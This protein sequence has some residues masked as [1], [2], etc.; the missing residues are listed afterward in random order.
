MPPWAM[1]LIGSAGLLA[2]WVSGPP[3]RPGSDCRG[4]HT[5]ASHNASWEQG[6]HRKAATC[7]DCHLPPGPSLRRAQA[8]AADGLR[9]AAIE[10][11]HPDPSAIRLHG[12]G[13]EVVQANCLRCHPRRPPRPEDVSPRPKP[14][15]G[16]AAHAEAARACA[17]C[18]R[19][20]GHGR[21]AKG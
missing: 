6:G 12:A 5:M 10:T 3:P 20:T 7:G 18:H 17:E 13:A 15:P 1:S 14:V 21:L 16:T 8:M 9:H 2:V 19:E 11:R 4:C